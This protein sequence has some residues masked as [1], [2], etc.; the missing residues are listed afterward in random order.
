M[1]WI[2]TKA[3]LQM[4]ETITRYLPRITVCLE[5][6]AKEKKKMSEMKKM[7]NLIEKYDRLPKGN[8]KESMREEMNELKESVN[9]DEYRVD[10][11]GLHEPTTADEFNKQ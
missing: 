5:E 7:L 2:Q 1:N 10:K 9:Y 3:G 11:E 6:L 4:A 8:F